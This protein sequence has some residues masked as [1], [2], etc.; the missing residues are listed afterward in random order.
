MGLKKILAIPFAKSVAKKIKKWADKPLE[1]QD[2]VFQ[3]LIRE[4]AQTQFGER[5]RF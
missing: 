4:A 3:Y 2:E 5:P 1:T